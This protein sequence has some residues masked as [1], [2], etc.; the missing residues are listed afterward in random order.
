MQ[1]RSSRSRLP[2]VYY[3]TAPPEE[4]T[5]LSFAATPGRRG[6]RRLGE[7]LGDGLLSETLATHAPADGA[8]LLM[9][10]TARAQ[11]GLSGAG[12]LCA[13][14]ADFEIGRIYVDNP[15]TRA[16]VLPGGAVFLGGAQNRMLLWPE[17]IPPG[18]KAVEVFCVEAGR[19]ERG[20]GVFRRIARAPELFWRR[21]ADEASAADCSHDDIQQRTWSRALETLVLTDQLNSTLDLMHHLRNSAPQDADWIAPEGADGFLSSDS[22]SGLASLGVYPATDAL[23][24]RL[25]G[26]N[27]EWGF[28]RRLLN[29][30]VAAREY[31]RVFDAA[32]RI[33]IRCDALGRPLRDMNGANF[34]FEYVEDDLATGFRPPIEAPTTAALSYENEP[35]IDGMEEWRSVLAECE[36]RPERITG[37]VNAIRLIFAHPTLSING[38]ALIYEGRLAE[39][40]ATAFRPHARSGS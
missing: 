29:S 31:F 22:R 17:L 12:A 23:R 39:L 19:W 14:E 32:R 28:R 7:F 11:T 25:Q 9:F 8:R 1:S 15:T 16:A 18:G 10:R 13:R 27:D 35:L 33:A 37:A 26:L 6:G 20:V 38:A 40:E 2:L 21:I 24:E 3:R 4:R 5:L 30:A 36:T 34:L